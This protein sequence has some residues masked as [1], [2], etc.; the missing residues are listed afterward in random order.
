MSGTTAFAGVLLL[1]ALV[2][3]A[4]ILV[5]R[6]AVR[7]GLPAPFFVLVAAAIA[8]QVFPRLERPS[9]RVVEDLVSVALV[10]VLFEGG[11]SIGWARFRA[12]WQ[13][14]GV[15]GVLGTF[16]TVAGVTLVAH[17]LGLDWYAALLVATAVSPTDPAVVFSVL[18][19]REISGRSG[20]VL[21]GESG[22]ND[23]VGI[24]LM[25]GL[26]GAGGIDGGAVG[27]V[28]RVFAEQMV[29]G[30]VVGMA[31]GWALLWFVRHV[32]LPSAGLHPLRTLAWS[33]AI[34]GIAVVA[35]G[36]GFLAVFLA[37]IV[38]GGV[39]TPRAREVAQFHAA[40]AS[41][42]EIVVFVVLG[43]TVPLRELTHAD[44]WV[45]GLVLAI[46]LTLVV[47]PVVVG[48]LLGGSALGRRERV[49][50]MVA[51]LKGAVPILLGTMIVASHVAGAERLY[52]IVV[53]VVVLS[54]VVQGALVPRIADRLGVTRA[55]A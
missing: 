21:E 17:G 7:V 6:V 50:V 4:A 41:L 29:I 15:I 44:V 47:R 42:A 14:I 30:A 3:L 55:V 38:I 20:T 54:V 36:S 28:S 49:F 32:P 37:G 26:V 33:M 9:E 23:P 11:S 8:V 2:A 22:A 25:V 52:G 40:L 27:H 45:P 18:G 43:M 39:S 35:H 46:V 10:V 16:A 19:Q 24:A 13:L 5:H 34:Y 31:G 12:A 51:G 48:A 1:V 53:V